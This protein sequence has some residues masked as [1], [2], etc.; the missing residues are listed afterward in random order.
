MAVQGIKEITYRESS[1]F[2]FEE[3]N[4]NKA[5]EIRCF[6]TSG[7]MASTKELSVG[8]I[9]ITWS[10]PARSSSSVFFT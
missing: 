1:F 9:H 2:H 3:Q 5:S 6:A 7:F 8:L 10:K 4:W